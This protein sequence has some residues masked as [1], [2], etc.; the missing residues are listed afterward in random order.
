[1]GEQYQMFSR[2]Y[3]KVQDEM[4]LSRF[5][6]QVEDVREGILVSIFSTFFPFPLHNST[7][8][9]HFSPCYLLN[10]FS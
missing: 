10:V 4:P 9:L 2:E 7:Y 8:P 6:I 5:K 1:M 3:D